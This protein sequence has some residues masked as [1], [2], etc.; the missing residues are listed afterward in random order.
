MNIVEGVDIREAISVTLTC[1]RNLPGGVPRVAWDDIYSVNIERT[2]QNDLTVV[3]TKT[4]FFFTLWVLE[5]VLLH[6][7]LET[8]MECRLLLHLYSQKTRTGYVH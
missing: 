4:F 3:S 6:K 1:M 2:A 7:V 8:F 5:R